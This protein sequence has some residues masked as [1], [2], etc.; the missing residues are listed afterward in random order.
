MIGEL[1]YAE[2]SPCP[3]LVLDSR[4]LPQAE[5]ALRE[6][7]TEARR[8]MI[9]SGA[10]SVLKIALIAP[11]AHPMFD[12]DYRFVQALPGDGDGFDFRGSCG[13]SILSS[14]MV[15]SRQGWV[16]RLTPGARVRVNVLNNGDN[17]VAE[18]D[19]VNR[20][21]SCFT[22]HF[23]YQEP[24]RLGDL[25]LLGVTTNELA[26]AGARVPVSMISMGNP[27]VFVAAD[28]V[29][30]RTQEELFADD[31]G[32][33]TRLTT[34]K[35]A[36]A[37]LLG[38]PAGGAF[39]KIAAVGQYLPGRLAVRA[40]SVPRWHP[41]LA[42]TG[43]TCLGIA[44]TIEDTIPYRLARRADC[45]PGAVAVDTAG[46]TTGVSAVTS[47]TSIGDT[48]RWVSVDRKFVRH[49]GSLDIAPFRHLALKEATA[50][51]PLSASCVPISHPSK[52]C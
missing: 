33:F 4:P 38:W 49:L 46:G 5:D 19:E 11:S 12:L 32:L 3:T 39:P 22:V 7:L 20:T 14:I 36:A 24:K 13:H 30:V 51:L 6:Q 17:V 25:L 48:V 2:G 26:L 45:P 35:E 42:L 21:A 44:A 16:R 28:D 10:E 43:T 9:S 15:A 31:P 40:I 41:T 50:C 8:W 29:G 37:D 34:L 27:Y 23:V 1:A 18:V 47:G 52:N